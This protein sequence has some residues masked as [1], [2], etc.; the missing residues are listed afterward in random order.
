MGSCRFTLAHLR[1]AKSTRIA[2]RQR[3][4]ITTRNLTLVPKDRNFRGSLRWPVP[5]SMSVFG[6][7]PCGKPPAHPLSRT[8]CGLAPPN[9]AMN[10]CRLPPS[11]FRS[12]GLRP[13]WV[14]TS[15]VSLGPKSRIIW[16]GHFSPPRG[17]VRRSLAW[18]NRLFF[19]CGLRGL[20]IRS[21]LP[22]DRK[23]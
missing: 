18:T 5:Y 7:A 3:S 1:T 2:Q 16:S 22:P 23:R 17:K 21:L 12:C 4:S 14:G 10:P 19:G 6:Q 20:L 8:T 9:R 13:Q 15:H 11:H